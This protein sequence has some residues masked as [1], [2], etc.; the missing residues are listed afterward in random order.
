M[1]KGLCT[2]SVAW[3]EQANG[4]E[5]AYC[6]VTQGDV[7][8]IEEFEQLHGDDARVGL[9]VAQEVTFLKNLLSFGRNGLIPS[10]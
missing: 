5:G 1:L 9:E 10:I 7:E 6:R 3:E 2:V 4:P 8:S